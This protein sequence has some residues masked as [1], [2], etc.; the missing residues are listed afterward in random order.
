MK[1]EKSIGKQSKKGLD[2]IRRKTSCFIEI[3]GA[4]LF[5]MHRNDFNINVER[6]KTRLE[7][8][9]DLFFST[10][11]T[12]DDTESRRRENERFVHSLMI[13]QNFDEK[14]H[15]RRLLSSWICFKNW[16]FVWNRDFCSLSPFLYL[17][18]NREE[19]EKL[20]IDAR[21]TSEEREKIAQRKSL[22]YDFSGVRVCYHPRSLPSGRRWRSVIIMLAHYSSTEDQNLRVFKI[23]NNW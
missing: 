10:S 23:S 12:L 13:D 7:I 14:K 21:Q 1:R 20:E 2:R 11:Q 4:I 15:V 17:T 9:V 3:V 5:S 18:V 16:I 19:T 22:L 8:N 6:R